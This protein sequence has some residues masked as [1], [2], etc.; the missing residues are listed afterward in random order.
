MFIYK[1]HLNT[2]VSLVCALLHLEEPFTPFDYSDFQLLTYRG[3]IPP[4]WLLQF[5][6][7]YIQRNHPLL[8]VTL[9]SKLLHTA[10]PPTPF[11]YSSFQ[12][13]TY[14]GTIHSFWL[15]KF[16][17]SYIQ[18]NHSLLLVT[19]VSNLLHTEEPSTPFGYSG[20]QILTYSG[21]IHSFWL[22]RFPTS[23]IQRNHP[24]L[25]VTPVS[26]FLH[27]EEPSTPFGYSSFHFIHTQESIIRIFQKQKK[28]VRESPRTSL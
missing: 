8:L 4:F 22:L 28:L 7:S 24:L 10:E 14:R 18:R 27:T 16:P 12:L 21:T 23:Y 25:L 1:K 19:P 2:L 26:N 20:F 17:T 9:V 15:L 6:T 11:G 3:I 5:P 13:F